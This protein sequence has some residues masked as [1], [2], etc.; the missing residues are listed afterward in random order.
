MASLE[1]FLK[2]N[3]IDIK[4]FEALIL[5]H[6]GNSYLELNEDMQYRYPEEWINRAFTWSSHSAR[7]FLRYRNT[8]TLEQDG[9]S[10][11]ELKTWIDIHYAWTAYINSQGYENTAVTWYKQLKKPITN[12]RRINASK[13]T[14]T[15]TTV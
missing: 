14:I 6:N 11:S 2:D 1:E 9:S 4:D 15:S 5:E 12:I 10:Y 3:G 8:P 13:A 7:Q